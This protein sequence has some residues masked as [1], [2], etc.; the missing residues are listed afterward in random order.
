[1]GIL[2]TSSKGSRG[3]YELR[4]N[5]NYLKDDTIQNS[6]QWYSEFIE[7]QTDQFLSKEAVRANDLRESLKHWFH[8]GKLQI[9]VSE[10][11]N[12]IISLFDGLDESSK[13]LELI[14]ARE[15][16]I[17]DCISEL[18]R[19]VKEETDQFVN[20]LFNT[21]RDFLESFSAFFSSLEISK[22]EDVREEE[23]DEEFEDEIENE[24][25]ESFFYEKSKEG[26]KV[27]RRQV[28]RIVKRA[29]EADAKAFVQQKQLNKLSQ[30]GEIIKW[31]GNRNSAEKEKQKLGIYLLSLTKLKQFLSIRLRYLKTLPRRYKEFREVCS[32]KGKWYTKEISDKNL[33]DSFEL[34][35][36]ILSV[37]TITNKLVSNKEKYIKNDAV[38]KYAVEEEKN[39]KNQILVDEFSDFSIIQLA[40]MFKLSHPKLKSFFACGDF[41]QRLTKKGIRNENEIKWLFNDVEIR[42]IDSIYRQSEMLFQ[43]STAIL[44]ENSLSGI[45]EKKFLNN[46]NQVGPALLESGSDEEM[47]SWVARRICEIEEL[48]S[49][50]LR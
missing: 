41:N 34:D 36:I 4:T 14:E 22:D 43:I 44:G 45:D 32:S 29:I 18:D 50:F 20:I 11:I 17:K 2:R 42:G 15:N 26:K 37:L 49:F 3:G 33:I 12:E 30:N 35:M 38:Y 1:M 16:K 39:F 23:E 19:S 10:R 47:V 31:L 24:G 8:S 13:M 40:C 9:D 25:H 6:I 21:D 7:W 28:E 5:L 48:L 46:P 27:T